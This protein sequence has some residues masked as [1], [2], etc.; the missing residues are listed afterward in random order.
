M[1]L[2]LSTK[3]L[4]GFIAPHELDR[5]KSQ[6]CAAHKLLH[7][8]EL[9]TEPGAGSDF[10]GWLDLPENYDREEFARVK[11]AAKKIYAN[12]DVVIAPISAREPLSSLSVRPST[13]TCARTLRTSTS[14]ETISAPTISTR[15]SPSVRAGTSP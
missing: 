2:S 14:P 1:P 7:H 3:Y 4:E 8:A 10:L 9:G 12:S 11:L 15:Y 5:V 13:T 6:V